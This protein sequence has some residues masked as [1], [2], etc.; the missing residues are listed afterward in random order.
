[1]TLTTT[2]LPPH[3][4]NEKLIDM[5]KEMWLIRYFDEKV[6]QFFAKGAIH[7]TTHLAVGQEPSATGPIAALQPKDKITSTH[8][9]HGH[10][11]AKGTDVNRM[12]A[13]LFGKVDGYCKGKG[14]SMHIADL[15]IGNLGANGIV[16]G[17][18]S[19]AV[20]AAL[21][22]KMK[23]SGYVVL[24]YFGDGA[25]NEGAFHE[26]VNLASVW[27]LPVVFFCENNQ[28]G[29]SGSVK[30]MTNVENI[31]DRAAAYGIPGKVVDGTDVIEMLNVTYEAVENARKGNGPSI[32]EAKTY[33][34]KGHSK[35]DAKLYRTREEENEWKSRDGIKKFKELL[36]AE[37]LLTEEKAKELQQEAKKEIEDSVTFAQN[38]PEPTIDSLFEDVYA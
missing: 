37:G 36:I 1:M 19:I 25:S 20:G 38:S 14:G 6:D 34:W 31:A 30:D 4:T 8:R 32:I 22:S 26:S 17:G 27:G 28:Y 33:R 7:G 13:E 21:T 11:I 24:C 18:I 29:M 23:N 3:I 2:K 16:A 12:M 10:S 15:E 9:G 5:Y 35:S